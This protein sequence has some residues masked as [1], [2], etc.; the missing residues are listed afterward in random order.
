[1]IIASSD[2]SRQ[3]GDSVQSKSSFV[4]VEVVWEA[5]EAGLAGRAHRLDPV[6]NRRNE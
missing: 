1:M 5:V 4:M 3:C 6:G 2:F